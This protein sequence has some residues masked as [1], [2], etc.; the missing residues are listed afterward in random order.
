MGPA[1]LIRPSAHSDVVGEFTLTASEAMS[2][3]DDIAEIKWGPC[4]FCGEQM[5]KSLVDPCRVTVE[6]ASGRWQL[7]FCHAEC[8]RT[9]LVDEPMLEPAI[10]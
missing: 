5:N 10:F 7:W 1:S 9:R 4:C 8:F 2:K 3:I 6:T